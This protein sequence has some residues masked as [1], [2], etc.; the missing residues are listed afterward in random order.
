MF[1]SRTA[2]RYNPESCQYTVFPTVKAER[3]RDT[4]KGIPGTRSLLS[5]AVTRTPPRPSRGPVEP[6]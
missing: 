2:T 6:P 4:A 1:R 3:Q 5:V